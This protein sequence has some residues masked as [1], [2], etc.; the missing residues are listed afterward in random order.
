MST[1]E[2]QLIEASI[3]G[4]LDKVKY[5]VENGADVHA[6]ND[7]ALCL[8]AEN[9]HFD[10]VKYLVENGTDIHAKNDHALCWSAKN[11]HLEVVR[12]LLENGADIHAHDDFALRL[13]AQKGHLEV[14]KYLIENRADQKVLFKSWDKQKI[15]KIFL[16]IENCYPA[17]QYTN[18]LCSGSFKLPKPGDWYIVWED[19]SITI[20][21]N[22]HLASVEPELVKGV[23][24]Q[25]L[26]FINNNFQ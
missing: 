14:V 3:D 24:V 23:Y 12:L 19:D 13:S 4:D 1:I 16:E 17:E 15:A 2:D 7:Y 18:E 25:K 26:K 8:S 9:G 20:F 10:I 11:G 5:L 22:V 21:E 6:D